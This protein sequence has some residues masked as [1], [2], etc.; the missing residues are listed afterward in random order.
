MNT[1]YSKV[2][3]NLPTVNESDDNLSRPAPFPIHSPANTQKAPRKLASG[4]TDGRSLR[5][6]GR[7]EMFAV[8]VSP[9]YQ[10]KF[11]ATA[12][13]S[14]RMLAVLFED[15]IDNYLETHPDLRDN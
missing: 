8:K 4:Y 7:T 9:E 1:N 10:I 11:R 14:G 5:R 2:I 12:E 3:G 13:K 6:T 15:M